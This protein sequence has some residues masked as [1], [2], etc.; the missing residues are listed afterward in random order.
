MTWVGLIQLAKGLNSKA[1][2]SLQK[3]SHLRAWRP[4]C[5][6]DSN[7]LNQPCEVPANP[8]QSINLYTHTRTHIH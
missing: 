8:L 6:V 3:T 7:L 5:P 4:S 2:V 1:E